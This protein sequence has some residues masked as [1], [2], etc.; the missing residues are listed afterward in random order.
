VQPGLGTRQGERTIILY[1]IATCIIPIPQG[2]RRS[3]D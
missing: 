2:C 1:D 3:A